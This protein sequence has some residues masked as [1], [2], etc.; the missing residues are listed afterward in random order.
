MAVAM[1]LDVLRDVRGIV[2]STIK[3]SADRLDIDAEFPDLGVDSIIAM[4][5]MEN[6][7]RH[8]A[9]AF[10]PAQFLNVNTV[11][12][13][14]SFIE[15]HYEVGSVATDGARGWGPGPAARVA[16][17]RAGRALYTVG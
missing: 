1:K 17:A 5:L 12:E 9:I 8:F 16:L 2:E 14:A 7:S 3:L 10:T 6:L 15:D 13:L 11:R 4:E